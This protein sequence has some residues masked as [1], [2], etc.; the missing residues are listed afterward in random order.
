MGRL[1]DADVD[2]D[3]VGQLHWTY[4]VQEMKGFAEQYEEM[5]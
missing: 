5:R 1:D 2:N 3:P 4:T